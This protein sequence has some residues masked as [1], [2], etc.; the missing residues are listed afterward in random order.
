[1][2]EDQILRAYM[3]LNGEGDW[4]L[5]PRI[6]GLN[7]NAQSC[8]KRWSDY[9]R[10]GLK[11]GPFTDREKD[12]IVNLHTEYGNNWDLLAAKVYMLIIQI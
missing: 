1:M 7:R 4:N 10:P 6:T 11:Q 12:L 5:V 9:L 3:S 8:R 2:E